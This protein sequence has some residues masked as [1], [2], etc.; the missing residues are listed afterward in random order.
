MNEEHPRVYS[1]KRHGTT[2]RTCDSEPVQ[3]PGCV[4]AHGVLLVLRMEEESVRNV[5]RRILE[6]VGYSVLV[7][8]DGVEALKVFCE[9]RSVIRL[10]VLDV[11]MPH[12]GG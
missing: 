6:R 10:V 2:L 7:A 8:S 9:K 12:M 5:T 3:T 11:T 4:Q 1:T